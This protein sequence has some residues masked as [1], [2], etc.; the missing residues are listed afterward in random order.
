[1]SSFFR[2]NHADIEKRFFQL[3]PDKRS[4]VFYFSF[5]VIFLFMI[6]QFA[7][8]MLVFVIVCILLIP[9]IIWMYSSCQ[10]GRG[11]APAVSGNE[12]RGQMRAHLPDIR[13]QLALL[14][15]GFDDREDDVLR[16]MI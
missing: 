2:G 12:P 16:M 11:E 10:R 6:E 14:D 13:T 3:L 1:M 7:P 4:A 15:R 8:N 5:M 9:V